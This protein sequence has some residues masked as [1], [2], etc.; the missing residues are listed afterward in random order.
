MR[1]RQGEKRGRILG[2]KR[3]VEEKRERVWRGR[4]KED[5]KAEREL[6]EVEG[7]EGVGR[8]KVWK[9]VRKEG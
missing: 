7:G 2:G 8:K 5:A 4:R 6:K 1:E 9:V 3:K